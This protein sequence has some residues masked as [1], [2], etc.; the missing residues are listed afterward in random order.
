MKLARYVY[1]SCYAFSLPATSRRSRP[2]TA[3]RP[4]RFRTSTML[5]IAGKA[6]GAA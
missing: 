2:E 1:S 4:L 6:R 3:G 5:L